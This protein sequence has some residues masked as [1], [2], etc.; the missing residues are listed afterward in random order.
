MDVEEIVALGIEFFDQSPYAAVTEYAPEDVWATLNG[1][2]ESPAGILL[3]AYGPQRAAQVIGFAAAVVNP[4]YFNASYRVAT[5]L[6][7]WVQPEYRAG[8][9]RRLLEHL[10][11]RAAGLGAHAM[12]MMAL[13]TVRPEAVAR[14]L[15]RSGYRP[16]ERSF[17]KEL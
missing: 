4:L 2:I 6:F 15:Q 11:Q 8:T 17:V 9:G 13:E 5:E 3:V 10:E 14:T 1:L 7:W 12:Q 16:V